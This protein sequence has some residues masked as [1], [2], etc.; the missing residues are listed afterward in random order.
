MH[1]SLLHQ[2]VGLVTATLYPAHT[3]SLEIS[4]F[5]GLFRQKVMVGAY[6]AAAKNITSTTLSPYLRMVSMR[7]RG[8]SSPKL[9]GGN[10]KSGRQKYNEK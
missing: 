8:G 4:N 7:N 10:L 5:R 6:L 9:K 3:I 1:A 2:K